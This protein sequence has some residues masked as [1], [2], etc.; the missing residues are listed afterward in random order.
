MV[1]VL[2][3][4][5]ILLFFWLRSLPG[6]PVSAICGERCNPEK[7]AAIEKTLSLDD[8]LP[9]QYFNFLKRAVTGDFG[10]STGV[11]PGRPSME[12]FLERLPATVELSVVALL[13]AIVAAIPLGYLAARRRGG[14]MDNLTVASSLLG[15]AV[16]VFFIAFILR[17][18]FSIEWH[19]FP[20]SGRQDDIGATRVTGF[21]V[22]DGLLTRE[23]DAAWNAVKHLILPAVA[24]ST[25]PFT[26]IF[27]ITRAAVLDV[28]DEDYVRTAEAKGLTSKTISRR[29]VL[30]NA[31]LP[32]V[33]IIGL[34][35]GALLGGA[36]LTETVFS[37]PGLGLSLR[38]AFSDRDYSMLQLLILASAATYVVVNLLV[39]IAY[40][41]IDPRVRTR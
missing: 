30:R 26:F 13:L 1:G 14:I 15:I 34:Q 36:I 7:R 8:P 6:G 24:L 35:I 33:T 20:I 23:Y 10:L 21:F 39:D 38:E 19:V 29:H 17:Y 41:Y 12:I 28:L 5:S 37:F 40:A 2:L 32:V 27:R 4:L 3:L 31:M 25:I 16:P 11:Q 18:F 9:V 22:L